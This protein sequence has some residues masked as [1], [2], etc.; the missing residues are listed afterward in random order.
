MTAEPKTNEVIYDGECPV[1]IGLVEKAKVNVQSSNLEFTPFQELDFT[2]KE[3]K[4]TRT[5]ASQ[6]LHLITADGNQTQGASAVFQILG[7]FPGVWGWIG[8]FLQKPPFNWLA[9]PGYRLFARHRYRFIS[10]PKAF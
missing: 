9:E 5:E 7:T 8:R 2:A 10:R 4:I 3:T 1:C 6:S